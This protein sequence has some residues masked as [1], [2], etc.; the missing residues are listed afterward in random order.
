MSLGSEGI[1]KIINTAVNNLAK[2]A[3]VCTAAGNFG[4]NVN[5]FSPVSVASAVTV[6]AYSIPAN[7]LTS[8]SNYGTVDLLAPGKDIYSTYIGSTY[9]TYSG[10]SMAAPVVAGTFAAVATSSPDTSLTEL[11]K[12]LISRSKLIKQTN[13]DNTKGV[14]SRIKLTSTAKAAKTTNISVYTG[15]S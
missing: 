10:T 13:F 12:V 6:G 1:S 5:L 2:R 7:K 11:P 8:W 15:S 14:N 3:I 4:M 9:A